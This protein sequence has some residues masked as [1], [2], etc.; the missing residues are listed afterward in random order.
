MRNLCGD[1][2]AEAA[3]PQPSL[4]IPPK[5]RCAV[6]LCGLNA[7]L[8]PLPAEGTQRQAW[9]DFV[10][11]CPG[12]DMLAWTPPENERSYVCSLHFASDCFASSVQVCVKG[13][14]VMCRFLRTGAVPT[15][16]PNATVSVKSTVERAMTKSDPGGVVEKLASSSG[17]PVPAGKTLLVRPA[18][19]PKPSAKVL[20][21]AVDASGRSGV[22]HMW[23]TAEQ[24]RRNHPQKPLAAMV[25]DM[26]QPQRPASSAMAATDV[27]QDGGLRRLVMPASPHCALP[28]CG[29]QQGPNTMLHPLP[30]RGPQRQAWIDFVRHCPGANMLGWTPSE[31]EQSFLCSLH[32]TPLSLQFT[33][34][35]VR[36][37]VHVVERSPKLGAVPTVYPKV[38]DVGGVVR[39]E[40]SPSSVRGSMRLSI[41]DNNRESLAKMEQS[42]CSQGLRE[43]AVQC[44]RSMNVANKS[45]WYIAETGSKSTQACSLPSKVNRATQLGHPA[46]YYRT[47]P[48]AQRKRKKAPLDS[49]D[50]SESSSEEEGTLGDNT[51][52]CVEEVLPSSQ[53]CANGKNMFACGFC[54]R[55][56]PNMHS[57]SSHVPV[58]VWPEP[59]PCC[60]CTRTF[61]DQDSM[62]RHIACHVSEPPS[63]CPVCSYAFSGKSFLLH[64]LSH[65]RVKPFKCA[66]CSFSFIK[67]H[68]LDR[69][70][71][72]HTG[73]KSH[74]CH[75]CLSSFASVS[76]LTR[77][78]LRHT[79]EKPH[80]CE[81]CG[82]SFAD[83]AALSLHVRRR[84]M[85][86]KSYK[87][88]VCSH[89]FAVKGNYTAHMRLHSGEGPYKC[90]VCSQAF[91]S[92]DALVAHRQQGLC[93]KPENK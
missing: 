39:A 63:Q 10:R 69:H 47:M 34:R 4:A 45:T 7:V 54:S 76:T 93:N 60:L 48:W 83:K 67:K 57:L 1:M 88:N 33:E 84:H 17:S 68:G 15:Q 21:V 25:Q 51:D 24:L 81:Q 18:C 50:E 3:K 9:I 56:F 74:M 55:T 78:M 8:H 87:C 70:L 26:T 75:L 73:E 40:V 14:D 38:S 5:A 59:Y 72:Q 66:I 79:G 52:A 58:C 53:E 82:D 23:S 77:H 42:V 36:H 64:I 19:T 13:V 61:T 37:G 71:R 89:S 91:V 49:N 30:A 86:E 6:P 28:T 80:K 16:Y 62:K 43:V 41:H 85:G 20:D 2:A 44:R 22:G 46:D 11:R 65:L 92:L 29:R 27:K 31:H 12:A 32:F 90:G 35:E